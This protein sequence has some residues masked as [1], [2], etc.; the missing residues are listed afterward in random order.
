MICTKT[1]CERI[2]FPVL[3]IGLAFLVM[4]CAG[5]QTSILA[6]RR[7]EVL[8]IA[9]FETGCQDLTVAEEQLDNPEILLSRGDVRYRLVGCEHQAIYLCG[10]ANTH[11]REPFDL[12]MSGSSFT[13]PSVCHRIQ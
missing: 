9:R 6:L 4:S 12:L 5:P 11:Q 13:L 2:R 1:D 7:D 10:N 3:F 8:R